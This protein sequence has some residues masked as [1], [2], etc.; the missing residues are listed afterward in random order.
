MG[1]KYKMIPYLSSVLSNIRFETALDAFSESGVV[2][3]S[4]K[5]MGKQ[6]TANDFLHFS[7]TIAKAIVENPGVTLSQEDMELLLSPNKDGRNFIQTT[8][9]NLYFPLEDHQFLDSVWS[10]IEDLPLYK[11]EIAL[12]ALCLAAAR[13]QPRG[14]FTITD[15]RYDDGR[16]NMHLPLRELFVKAVE[17]YNNAVFDNGKINSVMCEDIFSID[18]SGFDLVY[19]DPP[20]APPKDDADYIKRYH[21]LEG[22]SRYWRDVKIM[23][24]TKTKKIEKRYTPFA[25][26]RTIREALSKLFRKFENSIIVLSYSSN[27]VPGEKEI[28]DLLREV[29]GDVEVYSVP[30][31]YSFG[32]HETAKRRQVNEYI[33]VAR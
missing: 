2:A 21:F 18:P 29:K 6:V 30:H 26:K 24:N 4:L 15:L 1:S 5:E 31:T 28:Y 12:S 10:H 22:L 17:E 13:K 23:E 33:F 16:K 19:F 14:V 32:T 25:Y 27:S 7:S 20:Y 11:R 9:Q 3:Y 8:F